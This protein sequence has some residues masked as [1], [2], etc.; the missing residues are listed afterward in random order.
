MVGLKQDVLMM[1]GFSG[2]RPNYAV[3]SVVAGL[4]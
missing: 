3:T 1:E 4:A 2:D